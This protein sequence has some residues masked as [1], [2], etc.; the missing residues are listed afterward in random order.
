MPRAK[1]LTE[2]QIKNRVIEKV[3]SAGIKTEYEFLALSPAEIIKLLP[4]VT[5]DE[6]RIILDLQKS[7][8]EKKLFS[9]LCSN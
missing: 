6:F 1:P 4:D 2:T 7:I 8:K 9:Y 5:R 3:S